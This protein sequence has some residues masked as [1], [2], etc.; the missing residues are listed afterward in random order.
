MEV[1][2]KSV[3]VYVTVVPVGTLL[4]NP[5]QYGTLRLLGRCAVY[6]IVLPELQNIRGSKIQRIYFR[7]QLK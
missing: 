2:Q 6:Q 3:S 1:T 5:T 4:S 7:V